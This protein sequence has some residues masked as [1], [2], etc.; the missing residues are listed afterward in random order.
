[1]PLGAAR[2]Q[3]RGEVCKNLISEGLFLTGLC[4]WDTRTLLQ[5]S[6]GSPHAPP[7]LCPGKEKKKRKEKTPSYL[8]SVQLSASCSPQDKIMQKCPQQPGE[9]FSAGKAAQGKASS[10]WERGVR[11]A[12]ARS[13]LRGAHRRGWAGGGGG[14]VMLQPQH[15][16]GVRG[17]EWVEKWNWRINGNGNGSGS[18]NGSGNGNG[19]GNGVEVEVE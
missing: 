9:F 14:K 8:F 5:S 18:G 3:T 13:R 1:M 12:G 2:G 6:S 19:T 7:R 17:W 16:G 15:V 4:H 11:T 10:G